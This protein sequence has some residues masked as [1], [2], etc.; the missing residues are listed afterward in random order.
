MIPPILID[1]ESAQCDLFAEMRMDCSSASDESLNVF[2]EDA[3][4]V[5]KRMILEA[6]RGNVQ[7]AKLVFIVY[8]KFMQETE[9]IDVWEELRK[10]DAQRNN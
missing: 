5:L 1:D 3:V 4:E 6:K 2:K 8:P 7:A 9:E 10:D